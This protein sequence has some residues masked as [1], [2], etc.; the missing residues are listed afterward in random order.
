MK[1]LVRFVITIA[2]IVVVFVCLL[3]LAVRCVDIPGTEW[4]DFVDLRMLIKWELKLRDMWAAS[5]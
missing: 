1:R 4:D 2:T 3:L 5:K